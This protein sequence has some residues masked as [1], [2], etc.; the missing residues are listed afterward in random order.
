MTYCI[1]CYVCAFNISQILENL[2][3]L[4]CKKYAKFNIIIKQNKTTVYGEMFATY[5]FG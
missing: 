1:S 4:K 2:Q 3:T 5:L